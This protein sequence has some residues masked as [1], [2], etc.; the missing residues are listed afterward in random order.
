MKT[1]KQGQTGSDIKKLQQRL[2]E[3]GYYLAAIDGDFGP[4]TKKAVMHFQR[5]NGLIEDGVVGRQTM[6]ELAVVF[7]QPKGNHVDDVVDPSSK[8]TIG[9]ARQ[10]CVGTSKTN[11]KKNLPI[12]CTALERRNLSYRS[13]ILM[14]VA[15]IY[16]ETGQF[17]PLDEG[18]SKFNTTP[19]GHPFDKYDDRTASLG[20]QG[21][22]DGERYKGRGYIQLTGRA[23]YTDI[24]RRIDIDL[25]E[26]PELANDPE[27]A[28][29][30]LAEFLKRSES[31]IRDALFAGDL[32]LARRLV[33]GGS[34]GLPEFKACFKRGE[35][36]L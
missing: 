5:D 18:I 29:A 28:A 2:K 4:T 19:S 17:L 1:L 33:N 31:K 24:G 22:P 8:M 14:A 26:Q 11:I 6:A 30:I 16:V 20:N 35:Q 36:L 32:K 25:E 3:L 12:I 23:N 27:I 10:M 34:H 9:I 21:A 13:M 15:T 7:E